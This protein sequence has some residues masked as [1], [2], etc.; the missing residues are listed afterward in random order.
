[1]NLAVF[2]E[3]FEFLTLKESIDQFN[4]KNKTNMNLNYYENLNLLLQEILNKEINAVFLMHSKNFP[5]IINLSLKIKDNNP[6][7]EVVFCSETEKFAVKGYK[8]KISY[9]LLLPIKEEE[10]FFILNEFSKSSEIITIKTNWQKVLVYV[11]EI[12][13]AEKQGHNV[14][15]HCPNK[16]LTTRITF[17]DF[18]KFFKNKPDFISCIRGTIVNLNWVDCIISQNFIMKTGEKIP[19]RRQDR[20]K[21]KEL[22]FNFNINKNYR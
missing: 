3:K 9:Y 17:K 16:T 11:N 22:L 6:K 14:I 15:I 5:D 1:M 10:L 12:I 2:G 4:F 18:M 19:I 13:F 21:I 20:K 7:C 8:L